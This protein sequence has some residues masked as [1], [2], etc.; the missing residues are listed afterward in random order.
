MVIKPWQRSQ[1]STVTRQQVVVPL[2]SAPITV[3]PE[4]R[5]NLVYFQ[6]SDVYGD[7]PFTP[8]I[9]PSEPFALGLIVKNV[10][11]GN[12]FNFS[13]T[14]AQPKIVDNEKGLLIDFNIIGTEVGAQSI[15]PSL[16]ANL[17]DIPPG[18]SREVTWELL[19]S[20]QGK[21]ISF[22]AT[23]KHEDD[24]GGTNTS[25]IK[26]IEIHELTHKVLANR[27]NDDN[28]PDFL[29]NDIADPDHLPDTLYLSDG[30]VGAVTVCTN[31]AVDAVAGAGHLQVQ[32][33]ATVGSGWNY[34]QIP[35]PGVGY[36]LKQVVRSDG[37]VIALADDAWTTDRSFPASDSGAVRE[38]L[39]HVFDYAGTGAYTLYYRSTNTTVPVIEQVVG[40]T[41]FTQSG[42]V[43][44][45]DV[46]FSE[47]IDASTFSYS[48]L[49]LTLNGGANLIAGAGGISMT[50]GSNATYSINGLQTL[51]AADG[52]YQITVNGNG[53]Y[54]LWGNNAANSSVSASWAKGNAPVVVQSLAATLPD[55]RNAP[56]AGTS[57]TFSKAIDPTTFDYNDLSLTLN[58]GANLITS[59]IAVTP[60]SSTTFTI[61][62]LG[63]LTGAEGNYVLTVNA[64]NIHDTGG[65]GGFGAQSVSWTM[66][67]TGP[68]ITSLEPLATNPRN[69]VVQSL[70]VAF[71]GPIDPATFDYND[72]TLTH[73]GGANLITSDVTVSQISSNTYKI[74]NFNWV[75]GYAGSYT[76]TVNAAGIADLAGN[77]GTGDTNETWQLILETPPS[78]TNLVLT[79]D[80]GISATDRVTSANPVLISGT[81]GVSNLTVRVFDVANSTDL[82]AADV[83][84]TN[85]SE[86]LTFTIQGQHHLK[87]TSVDSAGNVSIASFFDLFLDFIPL[88]A[89]IQQVTNPI[90]SAVSSIPVTFSE[91]INTNTISAANFVLMRD[92]GSSTTPTLT[93]VSSNQFSLGGISAF[94]SVLGSYQ[95]T[96]HL[97]G[98]Q[99]LA[100]NSSTNAVTM[101]WVRG[102]TN[103]V[104]VIYQITNVVVT[105]DGDVRMR[106]FATDANGDQLTYSLDPGAPDRARINPTNGIFSWRPTRTYAST[107]NSVT[108]RVTDDGY[109]AMSA[110]QSFLVT[111]LDYLDLAIGSTNVQTGD[112][113]GVPI[114][115][116]SSEGVSNLTFNLTWPGDRFTN[117]S[118]VVAAPAIASNSMQD[119]GTNLLIAARAAS[120]QILQS[121]QQQILRL[122][123]LAVTNQSSAFVPLSFG[124]V[125][126]IKPGNVTYS[127]YVTHP[128]TVAVVQ[129][130]PLLLAGLGTNQNRNLT[131]LGRLGTN[132]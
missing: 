102:A 81:V 109:P 131:L 110:A 8:E 32:L 67:T 31:A 15:S 16:T 20:L 41:P 108:V 83:A 130:K 74:A 113:V 53:I 22:D 122:N 5:L 44:T 89:I 114:Y 85:F 47:A 116:A 68:K 60:V 23:F 51:T 21:F 120:G 4:A 17:G 119:Q 90:Y 37:K 92:G 84:G 11:A 64:T 33:I 103:V 98:V 73:D 75:Q 24:L 129:D 35:D 77:A 28:V 78:P 88:A 40:P 3:Y 14:S 46:I 49:S 86:S 25:I 27:T 96:L 69:I 7:D 52:N 30:S 105:P 39:L 117:L 101:S 76:F 38:N 99:D 71:S 87:L 12:A 94:T 34:L 82:G 97:N 9:E 1:D 56:V 29:V 127:N 107:T 57:V 55:P 19:S 26:S 95:V 132:Y 54:D 124:S 10:G 42:A 63:A 112:S 65:T 18:S 48:N 126:A 6:Q 125:S 115:L 111:V 80:L 58:G 100:G 106:I 72:V 79:P 2:L 50:L 45:V 36:L 59:L 121:T 128:G 61:G 70:K 91:P 13:I 123:F 118:L 62:G 93:Y 43:S 104:P 66:I